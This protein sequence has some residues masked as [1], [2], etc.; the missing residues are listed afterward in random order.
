MVPSPGSQEPNPDKQKPSPGNQ[1]TKYREPEREFRLS[2][3][4]RQSWNQV[5]GTGNLD[6]ATIE[7]S[8][9]NQEVN[10]GNHKP[11]ANNGTMSWTLATRKLHNVSKEPSPRIQESST[12]NQK[13]S[14]GSQG[15]KDREPESEFRQPSAL[16][17]IMEPSPHNQDPWWG[18]HGTRWKEPGSEFRQP[19]T[20][21]RNNGTM[22]WTLATKKLHQATMEPSPGIQEPSTGTHKP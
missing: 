3:A 13:P 14:P 5:Q 18:N 6:Q 22:N 19:E 4:L 9:D 16:K 2:G 10:S 21:V 8:W 20:F 1:G 7:L 11:S 15:T 12:G 17:G